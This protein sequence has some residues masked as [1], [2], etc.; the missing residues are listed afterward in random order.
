M[1]GELALGNLKSRR[2]ILRLVR[3]LPRA[4]VA[5]DVETMAFIEEH[6]LYGTGIGFVDAQLLASTR[7]TPGARLWSTD[8]KLVAA[9]VRLNVAVATG[10]RH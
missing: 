6:L 1:L 8:K 5:T 7:L 9:A 3:D 10:G 2:E 4:A